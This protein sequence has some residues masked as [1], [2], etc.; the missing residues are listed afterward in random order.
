[1]EYLSMRT[2]IVSF[3]LLLLVTG[4]SLGG[5]GA[6]SS[7][8]SNTIT[9]IPNEVSLDTDRPIF[10]LRD[11]VISPS[12]SPTG[13]ITDTTPTFSWGA[14]SNATE[15]QL[16]HEDP[17][18]LTTWLSF[19]TSVS[20]AN[21][22]N[23][24]ETCS[25]TPSQPVFSVGDHRGWWVRAK[26]N[27]DW[28]EWSDP[29]VFTIIENPTAVVIP[30]EIAPAGDISDTS[31]EFSWSA[32]A[33]V[34][35]YQFGHEDENFDWHQYEVSKEQAGCTNASQICSFTPVDYTMAV[36]EIRT[37][38]VRASLNGTFGEWSDGSSFEIIEQPPV[39][40][41]IPQP[42]TP[43]GNIDN[44]SPLFSWTAITNATGY[45]LAQEQAVTSANRSEYT[46][47]PS[48][49][50]CQGGSQNCTFLLPANT[51]TNNDN[52]SWQVRAEVAGVLQEWSVKKSF[53]VVIIPPVQSN[54]IINE[55]LAANTQTNLDPDFFEFSDWIELF[56]PSNQNI[57]VSNYGLSDDDD[58][59]Q[60][61][62]PN[63]TII[64][65]NSYL[66]VW[67]DKK[68]QKINAL[69]TN[70]KLS[71]KGEKLTLADNTGVIIDTLDFGKQGS[72][73][74]STKINGEIVFMSP[75]PNALNGPSHESKDRSKEPKF[76][77]ESG[78]FSNQIVL[79][80]TQ[81]NGADIYYTTDGSTPSQSSSK[82]TQAINIADTAVVRAVALENAGFLS[83]VVS[84]TYFI[85]HVSTL[86][87]V[88]L[89]IDP[90]YLFDPKIGIYTDGDGS[91]GTPLH[92]CSSSYTE[93]KNYAQEWERPVHLEYFGVN[94][95]SE[96]LLSAGISISGQCSRR[97]EKK[98]F[99]FEMD[100]KF[101]FKSLKYKLFD[102]KDIETFKDFK[103]RGGEDGY[104]TS[105]LLAAALV[106]SGD[107]NVD[108]QAFK[109]V[110]TFVNGNYW[111][112]YNFREKKGAEYITSNYPDIDDEE[113][114]IINQGFE[115]KT[116]D[117]DDYY[118]LEILLHDL[119]LDL[120]NDADY[121]Q[122]L[123]LIDESNYIDYMA[124]MIYSANTDWIGSNQ[125]SWKEKKAGAKWRWMLDDV[126]A[127]FHSRNI[128]L[129]QFDT[130]DQSDSSDVMVSLFRSLTKNAT[131]RQKF[132]TRL[133]ALLD[134]TFST[135]NMI[136][137]IDVII[138]QRKDFIPLETPVWSSITI[139]RFDRYVQR[140]KDFSNAR[141]AILRTQLD[142]FIQ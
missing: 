16:G 108:Y 50:N 138:D 97:T 5:C 23:V 91:N 21:C 125:R 53:T 52:I 85:N 139:G 87:V 44:P 141:N 3:G 134:T 14:I 127:G 46:I 131:F 86:P 48:E 119:N 6:G 51:F 7:S 36:G 106:Q 8:S 118:A 114:D 54:I 122:I 55:V 28:A 13:N 81:D 116:G 56:N 124:L 137:Q 80:L 18:D 38:W 24:G 66:I 31:P 88:S 11:V 29:H 59:L 73:I 129:N 101:G 27:G 37:W 75:T 94:H 96:F 49:A 126:D 121:Q 136:S 17:N 68:D 22:Q 109:T 90:D 15:Y 92:Q 42:L 41:L 33:N 43:S 65:A 78:F 63:G 123:T 103:L 110:Q 117:T 32:V 95:E 100:S 62:M 25:Y 105:D 34:S 70:F 47:T 19:Q 83:E 102:E 71:S 99:S 76:S 130:L 142:S 132:K 140:I 93:P 1:M 58:P 39:A 77:F 98:S 120:S 84:N 64:N 67:A 135:A 111:G 10:V 128:N 115:A 30:Q 82:Y 9:N 133:V 2:R 4:F 107:L 40:D 113:L 26:I 35:G 72:D 104:K 20:D 69:H 112:L 74:S 60:W 61:K 89:T 57:D 12:Y 79:E 45:K